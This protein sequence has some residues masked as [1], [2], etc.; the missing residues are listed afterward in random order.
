MEPVAVGNIVM[1]RGAKHKL[2]YSGAQRCNAL[3]N[4]EDDVGW[5]RIPLLRIKDDAMV[6]IPFSEVSQAFLI[7]QEELTKTMARRK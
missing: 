2:G 4:E 1:L 7:R 5:V 3:R 6:Q